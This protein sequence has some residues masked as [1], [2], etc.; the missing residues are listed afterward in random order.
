[1]NRWSKFSLGW[2]SALGQTGSSFVV[3]LVYSYTRILVYYTKNQIGRVEVFIC[4]SIVVHRQKTSSTQRVAYPPDR[5][6]AHR[7]QTATSQRNRGGAQR[8][9]SFPVPNH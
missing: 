5:T 8:P 1:M 2:F 4:F 7:T 3:V 6:I 9:E